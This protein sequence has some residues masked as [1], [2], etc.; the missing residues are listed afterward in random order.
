MAFNLKPVFAPQIIVAIWNKFFTSS[1]F[2]LVVAA[3]IFIATLTIAGRHGSLFLGSKF[4]LVIAIA[5]GTSLTIVWR[6]RLPKLVWL[7]G[8][9]TIITLSSSAAAF[10]GSAVLTLSAWWIGEWLLP[11]QGKSDGIGIRIGRSFAVGSA[12]LSGLFSLF[13]PLPVF[14]VEYLWLFFAIPAC[15]SIRHTASIREAIRNNPIIFH[16]SA[17]AVLI[18]AVL[19]FAAAMLPFSSYDDLAYHL[20]L[21]SQLLQFHKYDLDVSAHQWA[22]A[23]WAGD[24]LFSL[25]WILTAGEDAAKG[26]LN[27]AYVTATAAILWNLMPLRSV[28]LR[29]LLLALFLSTPLV[30]FLIHT[31]HTE[32]L[33]GL[34]ALAAFS[35]LQHDHHLIFRRN[36]L[37]LGVLLG[38]IM[39]TKSTGA[40]L[41]APM[42]F[43]ALW[44]IGH[45]NTD[46]FVA[47]VTKIALLIVAG[48]IC[49]LQSYLWAYFKTGNPVFPLF[50]G[51]FK[52]SFGWPI[53]F[54]NSLYAG[55]FDWFLPVRL[56]IQASTV[57]ETPHNY[58]GG[59]H[60]LAFGLPALLWLPFFR[61]R[62]AWSATLI[63]ACYLIG[64][65]SAQQYLRYTY[66]ALAF[67]T[68]VIACAV[69]Y[70]DARTNS[71]VVI[72]GLLV[73]LLGSNLIA[74]PG[75][76]FDVSL[77]KVVLAPGGKHAYLE[78]QA[79]ERL[80]EQESKYFLGPRHSVFIDAEN[81]PFGTEF[82]AKV[83]LGTWYMPFVSYEYRAIKDPEMLDIFFRKYSISHV[84][85]PSESSIQGK[86]RWLSDALVGRA[87]PVIEINGTRLM[88]LIPRGDVP[89][90]KTMLSS[91]NSAWLNAG[92]SPHWLKD[93][94]V[95]LDRGTAIFQSFALRNMDALQLR[96]T[97]VCKLGT[98]LLTQVNWLA[99]SETI[100][101]D[102]RKSTCDESNVTRI[103][104]LTPPLAATGAVLYLSNP[105]S[106]TVDVQ[107]VSISVTR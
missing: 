23:P 79:P 30:L 67:L 57:F 36:A 44:K 97:F 105:F 64:V 107:S 102:Y 100:G 22:L 91:D 104:D 66:P 18:P 7:V 89:E 70:I 80:I 46:S 77:F 98:A 101:T 69:D 20:R 34:F 87:Y 42:A 2:F 60:Y 54:T 41:V 78:A 71:K 14:R 96:Q 86:T 49:G 9:I 19:L 93:G 3:A 81:R 15:L 48:G 43:L 6:F 92:G 16:W 99:G 13:L 52:S 38:G 40:F 5:I 45:N 21:P 51:I 73:L 11:S 29:A 63:A 32:L 8:S 56:I 85:L 17:V 39:A 24:L 72:I 75:L 74:M 33:A 55:N 103:V 26:W 10:I 47:R 28:R 50:N 37:A 53:N 58:A 1:L 62:L 31:L 65:M 90:L 68:I 25:A 82:A 35:L 12:A 95:R 27:I 106:D 4:T 84:L 61:S 59:I 83:I 76:A 94:G 88:K